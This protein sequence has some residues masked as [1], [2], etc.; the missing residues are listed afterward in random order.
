MYREFGQSSAGHVVEQSLTSMTEDSSDQVGVK[1]HI[2][3]VS[4]TLSSD[5]AIFRSHSQ[6]TVTFI[7]RFTFIVYFEGPAILEEGL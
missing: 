5:L 4:L 1:S 3:Q 2:F 6:H 7:E